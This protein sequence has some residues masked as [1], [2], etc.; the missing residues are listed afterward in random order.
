M[1]HSL[2]PLEEVYS[3]FQAGLQHQLL[4]GNRAI[5]IGVCA[6]SPTAS[7]KDSHPIRMFFE[8]FGLYVQRNTVKFRAIIDEA[9]GRSARMINIERIFC[10]QIQDIDGTNG[11]IGDEAA[12]FEKKGLMLGG[13]VLEIEVQ[14]NAWPEMETVAQR[15]E[16]DVVIRLSLK[17]IHRPQAFKHTMLATPHQAIAQGIILAARPRTEWGIANLEGQGIMRG[18]VIACGS[19]KLEAWDVVPKL[20]VIVKVDGSHVIFITANGCHNL[21][22]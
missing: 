20:R 5:R 10:C 8:G 4:I 21:S 13:T 6:P 12:I 2:K 16:V 3:E 11:K 15:D 22:C 9:V 1:N 14:T 18:E 19:S 7:G 17:K